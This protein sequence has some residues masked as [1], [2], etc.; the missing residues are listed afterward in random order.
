MFGSAKNSRIYIFKLKSTS[1]M[2]GSGE[3]DGFGNVPPSNI[4][5]ILDWGL[6]F[7]DPSNCCKPWK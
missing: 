4:S 3:V 5:A 2:S 7:E 1:E 6:D